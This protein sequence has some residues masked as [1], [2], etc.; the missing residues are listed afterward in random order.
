MNENKLIVNGVELCRFSEI[1]EVKNDHHL[2]EI[3]RPGET[4]LL[5]DGEPISVVWHDN[6]PTSGHYYTLHGIQKDARIQKQ[7][8]D[9]EKIVQ[10]KLPEDFELEKLFEVYRPLL[11]SGRYRL[12]YSYP[13]SYEISKSGSNRKLKGFELHLPHERG[14]LYLEG[15]IYLFSQ[16]METIDEKR[17]KYYEEKILGGASPIIVSLGHTTDEAMEITNYQFEDSYPQFIL[18]GHHKALAYQ[19]INFRTKK[20]MPYQILVPGVFHIVKMGME[21]ESKIIAKRKREEA[22][23]KM[24][25]EKEVAEIIK[26]YKGF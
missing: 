17:V 22:L 16:S 14:G 4:I 3:I 7:L 10:D 1:I 12:F 21:N 15:G 19:N 18:D 24:L 11:K 20:T 9:F 26:L 2:F 5:I 25:S 13:H 6:G 23:L 8:S